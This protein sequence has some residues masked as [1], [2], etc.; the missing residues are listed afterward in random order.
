MD[1]AGT[2]CRVGVVYPAEVPKIWKKV[3]PQIERC[4]P[5]SEGEMQPPDFYVALIDGDAVMDSYGR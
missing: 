3:R 5:H 1:Q 2:S 4:V